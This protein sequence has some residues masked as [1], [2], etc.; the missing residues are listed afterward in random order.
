[1]RNW[2]VKFTRNLEANDRETKL[3]N[4]RKIQIIYVKKSLIVRK[5]A[6]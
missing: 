6:R 3:F 2:E 5:D 4:W 1:M